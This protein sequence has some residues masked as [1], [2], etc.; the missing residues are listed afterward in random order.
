MFACKKAVS[1][2][3]LIGL[4]YFVIKIKSLAL[5][6]D[7]YVK[8]EMKIFLNFLWKPE[9]IELIQFFN[10]FSSYPPTIEWHH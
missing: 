5:I 3:I 4:L 9:I 6:S 10:I 7:L 8:F 2:I 1:Q